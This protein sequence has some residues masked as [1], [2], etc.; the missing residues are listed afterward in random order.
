MTLDSVYRFYPLVVATV[1]DA[2]II[3][4][5]MFINSITRSG[6]K[7]NMWVLRGAEERQRQN[8]SVQTHCGEHK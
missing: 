4:K 5:S 3:S 2:V 7:N 1:S 6:P 8:L